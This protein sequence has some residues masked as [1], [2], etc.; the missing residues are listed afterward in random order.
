MAK[1]MPF[2]KTYPP[3]TVLPSLSSAKLSSHNFAADKDRGQECPR[4]TVV[5][6]V[7]RRSLQLAYVVF[8]RALSLHLFFLGG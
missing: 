8:W 6:L 2:P 5:P 7:Y 3:Q 1:A 4:L